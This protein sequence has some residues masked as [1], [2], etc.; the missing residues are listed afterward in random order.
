[1][2]NEI[3]ILNSAVRY[4]FYS[5]F[6]KVYYEVGGENFISNWHLEYLADILAEHRD[7]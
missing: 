2:S 6:Q 1:M 5:F 3:E 7:R 4:D